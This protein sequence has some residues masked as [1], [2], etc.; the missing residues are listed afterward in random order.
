MAQEELQ[1]ATGGM[2]ES[3][4]LYA[5]RHSTAHVMAHAIQNLWP[6]AKFAIGP[7]IRDGFYYDIELD[8]AFTPD[9]LKKIEKEMKSI[10]KSR[11]EFEH[12]TWSSEKAIAYF[13]EKSQDYKIDL[14]EGIGEEEVSIYTVG[15]FLDL[16][17]GPH[18]ENAKP[19]KN[20]K[21]LSLA[22]AY[23]RGDEN[24]TMLQRIYGTVWETKDEL[25]KHLKHLEEAKRRDHRVLG[26]ELGLFMIEPEEAGSGMIFWLP[27][28]TV[29]REQVED[30]SRKKHRE[31]GYVYVVTPHL[32]RKKLF[33]TSGHYQWYRENMFVVPIEEENEEYVL[34]PMNCPGHVMVFKQ[35][36]RS[37]RELPL[38]MAELGT[39]YRYERSGTLHGLLRVR[40]F[41]QDDSHIFCTPDQ[42]EQEVMQVLDFTKEI[43]AT[44]GFNRWHAELS[45][46]DPNNTEKYAGT[47]EEWEHAEAAL[48]NALKL[49]GIDAVRMEGEAVFYGPKIDIKLVDALDRE[50]QA[51][52]I[53]FDFNLPRRFDI[54]YVGQDGDQHRPVMIHRAI[55]GSVERFLGLL[56]EHY[57]G[58]FPTWMAPTQ[59]R[60][61][62]ITDEQHAYVKT[63]AQRLRAAGLRVEID[64]SNNKIGKKVREAEVK[65]TPYMLVVGK[66]EA[67][68]DTVA[69]R[70]YEGGD[71]GATPVDEF[72]EEVVTVVRERRL[73]TEPEDRRTQG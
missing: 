34:K 54:H 40:G 21:L 24:N 28:G 11:P 9:D 64:D 49:R 39:V 22:G 23:W 61:L 44:F 13:K 60:I 68:E 32:F 26:P 25:Y 63:V 51:S 53:Q 20:F 1:K 66:R 18:L 2:D 15:D 56:I 41:T 71:R 7:P 52:T 47:D 3:G 55:F 33:E 5:L 16:C 42:V 31:H 12:E 27:N 45:V 59:V 58:A 19:I 38:R 29:L 72:I 70:T 35:G 67:E 14:I 6:D 57:A 50:W 73:H 48:A 62:P 37:Y 10:A 46:R 30:Y 4:P 69:V 65:K 8:H 36:V 17:K 43:L